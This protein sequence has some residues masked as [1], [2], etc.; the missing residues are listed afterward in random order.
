[1][2]LRDRRFDVL[3]ALGSVNF[4][5]VWEGVD[6]CGL[7]GRGGVEKREA[8]RCGCMRWS[9]RRQRQFKCKCEESVW[10]P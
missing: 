7:A 2:L 6:I 5:Q 4:R 9:S 10:S 8:L 1:M 3:V